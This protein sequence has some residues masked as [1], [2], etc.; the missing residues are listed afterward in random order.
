MKD[1]FPYNEIVS[2]E[3]FNI[4][5]GMNYRPKGKR[6]SI[7][8]MSVRSGAPYNDGFDKEGKLLIYEGEDLTKRE[9]ASP[10]NY[11]QPFF[12]K[13]GKLTNNGLFLKA[14]EDFKFGRKKKPELVKVYEK[15]S[16]NVWSDKGYFQLIDMQFK[17]SEVEKRQVFKFILKPED[18]KEDF[19]EEDIKEF[20][21]SRRIPTEIKQ[22]V[23]ERDNGKCVKCNATENLHFDHVI[24]YSKGGS[25]L[26]L[27]NI[28]ILCG[29]HNLTKS[30]KIE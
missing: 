9:K 3:G 12:T 15:I 27:K 30:N 1:I 6:Y 18:L 19:S 4:Q 17:K 25:S 20:E 23:W 11:D 29:K 16:N 24:P 13:T 21:F 10:K 8:L 5:K 2:R 14:V 26:N 22:I 28:Q 7:L